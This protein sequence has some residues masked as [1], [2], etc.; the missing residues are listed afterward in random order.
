MLLCER[1]PY[2]EQLSKN[3]CLIALSPSTLLPHVMKLRADVQWGLFGIRS[4]LKKSTCDRAEIVIH[5]AI[6]SKRWQEDDICKP[7]LFVECVAWQRLIGLGRD[8]AS[9][10]PNSFASSFVWRGSD[11]CSISH[12]FVA[13]AAANIQSGLDFHLL[14]RFDQ[15][16]FLFGSC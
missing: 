12:L 9:Q 5:S 11:E 15:E 3:F 10:F 13:A 6:L 14:S 7:L 8:F 1:R 2:I 16:K 4:G